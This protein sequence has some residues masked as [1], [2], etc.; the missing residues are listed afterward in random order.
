MINIVGIDKFLLLL[1]EFQKSSFY[2]STDRIEVMK[3]E[4]IIK[5][6]KL[7]V[8]ELA[9][10]TRFSEGHVYSILRKHSDNFNLFEESRK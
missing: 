1:E 4:Y 2:F 10:T 5:N 6:K 9:K 7:G 8:R 3:R